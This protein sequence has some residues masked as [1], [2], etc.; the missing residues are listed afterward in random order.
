MACPYYQKIKYSDRLPKYKDFT[1]EEWDFKTSFTYDDYFGFSDLRIFNA[2]NNHRYDYMW[3]DFGIPPELASFCNAFNTNRQRH[4]LIQR[5]LCSNLCFWDPQECFLED[6]HSGNLTDLMHKDFHDQFNPAF[7]QQFNRNFKDKIDWAPTGGLGHFP[8][9][10]LN[11]LIEELGITTKLIYNTDKHAV[12]FDNLNRDFWNSIPV[13]PLYVMEVKKCHDILEALINVNQEKIKNNRENMRIQFDQSYKG[14]GPIRE[15]IL[16]MMMWGP[17]TDFH[18]K[19]TEE[20]CKFD[21][22][23]DRQAGSHVCTNFSDKN[24]WMFSHSEKIECTKGPI[25]ILDGPVMT[26]DMTIVYPCNRSGC[27]HN[28]MC[29][30]CLNSHKCPKSEHKKHLREIQRDFS[31]SLNTQCQ[32]HEISHPANFDEGEDISMQKNIFY[33]N[34]KLEKQ[35]RRNSTGH[36]KYAGIKKSCDLCRGNIKNHF[37]YHKVIKTVSF[38]RIK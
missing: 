26:L 25:K 36:L 10:G 27:N 33:H 31:V 13:R 4:R 38:V 8:S 5:H 35:P 20:E 22:F 11:K 12:N 37:K 9:I 21:S 3:D 2:Q 34:L 1:E 18:I 32:Q 19:K 23:R 17:Q 14:N 15:P 29:D 24:Y 6:S 28:C 7:T 30:L 16:S